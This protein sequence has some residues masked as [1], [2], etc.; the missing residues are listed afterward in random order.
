MHRMGNCPERD[1]SGCAAGP[2]HV[3]A[4]SICTKAVYGFEIE[5][6][7]EPNV[8]A[9]VCNLVSLVNVVPRSCQMLRTQDNRAFISIELEGIG[10]ALARSIRRRVRQ[11]TCITAVRLR[12][13]P[14]PAAGATRIGARGAYE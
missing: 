7:A 5:G 14:L 10:G 1:P 11:L 8:L 9:L 2:I 3:E 13:N 4:I 6:D 12:E